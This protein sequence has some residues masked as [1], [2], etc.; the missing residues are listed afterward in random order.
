MALGTVMV[1][2]LCRINRGT[3]CVLGELDTFGVQYIGQ[4]FMN[5]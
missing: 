2:M 1:I 5:F 4:Y 3:D